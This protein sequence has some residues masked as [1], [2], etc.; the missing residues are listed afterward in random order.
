MCYTFLNLESKGVSILIMTNEEWDRKAEF[1]LNQQA[2]F[3]AEMHQLEQRQTELRESQ[4]RT[5]KM[6]AH[7]AETISSLA[8]LTFEGFKI[9]DA[10]I[11]E[12]AEAQKEL[13]AS[14][15]DTSEKL[16]DLARLVDRHI[17]GGLEGPL[18][19]ET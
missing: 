9:T 4:A 8:S 16:K 11:R 13:A 12:V 19:A 1:L 7:A 2:R 18:G 6:V 10:K 15:Q 5:D 17:R 3:D 14:Q